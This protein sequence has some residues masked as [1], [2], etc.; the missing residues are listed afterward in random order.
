MNKASPRIMDLPKNTEHLTADNELISSS[1]K[2]NTL[3]F[4]QL[5]QR[6]LP[7]VYAIC[8]RLAGDKTTAEEITQNCFVRVWQ[9]LD[10]FDGNSLFSTWLHRLCVN[11]AINDLNARNTFWKRFVSQEIVEVEQGL[12]Y[13][14]PHNDIE[15]CIA[16]LP[17]QTRIV[18]VLYAIEG[19]QHNEISQLLNIAVG[20]S[21]AHYFKAKNL[22][23]EML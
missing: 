4:K 1:L 14:M 23:K 7:R 21:K 2:G 10:K 22:L 13:T 9:K 17:K 3:A 19:Y 16:Q 11:Q 5:Y 12:A 6:H 20:T 18:F 15:Q 8:L